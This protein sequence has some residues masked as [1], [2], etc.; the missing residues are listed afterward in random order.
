MNKIPVVILNWNGLTDTISAVESVINQKELAKVIIIDNASEFI[1]REALIDWAATAPNVELILNE[2]NIGFAK[3]HNPIFRSL[4]NEG[5]SHVACLNND[6]I[7]DAYWLQA[8]D[9][10]RELKPTGMIASMMIQYY[11]RDKIDNLGH[12]MLN[13]AEIIPLAHGEQISKYDAMHK[14]L[15]ACA[16]GCLYDLKMLNELGYFDEYFFLGYEDA[17]LGI[18]AWLCGY[19]SVFVPEAKVYHKMGSSI[20]KIRSA[21]YLAEIQSHVFYTWFKLMPAHVIV[22]FLPHMVFKYAT[23]L[24]IDI[25]LLRFKFLKVMVSGILKSLMNLS[26]IRSS[27]QLFYKQQS[28]KRSTNEILE[29]LTPF[30]MYDVSRFWHLV[31]KKKRSNLEP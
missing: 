3:A 18:R 1:Q 4:F 7:A 26:K 24:I 5:Y 17:E 16:G 10:A 27:R 12:F 9:T 23:V 31:V 15:G 25:C 14:N 21:N 11:N 6:A 30:F 28:I 2:E 19:D 8:L 29:S 13:T 22:F 20:G